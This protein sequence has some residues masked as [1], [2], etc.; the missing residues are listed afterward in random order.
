MKIKYLLSG[1]AFLLV[2]IFLF[3]QSCAKEDSGTISS[4]DLSIAE[5]DTYADALFE[6]VDNLVNTELTTLDG[7]GYSATALKSAN[8]DACYTV[9]V[10]HPDSTH[11]PKQVYINFGEGCSVVFNGD[12]ITRKGQII[13]SVTDRWYKNG[14]QHTVSF[15][16]FFI[17]GVKI[18]GSKT[19]T[20]QGLTAKKHLRLGVVLSNGKIIFNDSTQLTRE[21]NHVREII[22][23]FNPQNDTILI[24]GSASGKNVL[25]EIYNRE[26]IEPIVL[27][28][29]AE[30]NW[31]WI[32][33]GGKVEITNI[34]RGTT[35]IDYSG[36][37]CD[38]N[39][40][41]SKDGLKH[42][43]NFKYKNRKNNN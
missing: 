33:S 20:N 30:Y 37:G 18:E 21:S 36:R 4:A 9:S 26:I 6:D 25:D 13:I 31:R 39:V 29:C 24:T 8:A 19:T 28:H 17:N 27:V 35:T 16:D 22:R 43:Y 11:F 38:G 1:L 7:N 14:A 40:I 3:T 42:N 23:R 32:I 15:N 12:T 10:D 34:K 5:D 41:I 2:A